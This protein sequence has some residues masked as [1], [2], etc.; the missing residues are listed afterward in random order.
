MTW[1]TGSTAITRQAP[2]GASQMEKAPWF[3]PTSRMVT[4]SSIS[5]PNSLA[6]TCRNPG[7][8]QRV[9]ARVV[10]PIRSPLVTRNL[11][12]GVETTSSPMEHL[13]EGFC[14]VAAIRRGEAIQPAHEGDLWPVLPVGVKDRVPPCLHGL[15]A[16][17]RLAHRAGQHMEGGAVAEEDLGAADPPGRPQPVTPGIAR[18]SLPAGVRRNHVLRVP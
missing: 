4:P 10:S 13:L 16:H 11:P 12:K 15:V 2:C 8:S 3:A 17:H 18:L 5:R 1:G 14:G 7:P 9:P 6:I